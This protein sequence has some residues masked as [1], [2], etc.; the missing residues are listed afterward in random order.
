MFYKDVRDGCLSLR[1]ESGQD[2]QL[3][4]LLLYVFK[5][6]EGN[7]AK[8]DIAGTQHNSLNDSE[9]APMLRMSCP[10]RGGVGV[11]LSPI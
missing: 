1:Y 5:V 6:S 10:F 3:R 9:G 11:C 4:S 8:N 2:E 7:L